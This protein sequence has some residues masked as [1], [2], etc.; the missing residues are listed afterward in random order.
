[1]AGR[2]KLSRR[3]TLFHCTAVRAAV[4]KPGN[5]VLAHCLR[6]DVKLRESPYG[7]PLGDNPNVVWIVGRRDP[8]ILETQI[9]A[10]ARRQKT[11]KNQCLMPVKN[12]HRPCNKKGRP[13][14]PKKTRR[15]LSATH[16]SQLHLILPTPDA[17]CRGQ[18][19]ARFCLT[20][21][22]IRRPCLE[23]T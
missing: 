17:H 16:S 3:S 10:A 12:W 23:P 20:P 19:P 5:F 2:S 21:F 8:L 18:A 1:M 4:P 13:N 11:L 6:A 22:A 9:H 14:R 7:K 15:R